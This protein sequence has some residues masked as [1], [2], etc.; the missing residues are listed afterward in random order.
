MAEVK[1]TTPNKKKQNPHEGHRKRVWQELARMGIDEDTH[2][3]KVLELVLFFTIPRKDTNVLA[4]NLLSYFNNSFVDVMEA[5]VEQLMEVPGISEYSAVHIKSILDVA[6]YYQNRKAKAEKPIFSRKSGSAYLVSM[7]TD[8]RVEKA[9]ML[10]LDNANRFLA[11]T[12]LSEGDELSVA[13]STRKII[14]KVT[15]IGATQVILAHN[16]PRGA[17]V[18]SKQDIQFT[19]KLAS[20]LSGIGVVF[21]DH[22]IVAEHDYVS[23]RD[24]SE[25]ALLFKI[26]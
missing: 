21:S 2:P 16:H 7:L 18:P 10:C 20:A 13:L 24:S 8:A 25:Y 17:A 19:S 6:R 9:Y 3:H 1:K 4:H 26:L 23:M 14:E 12:K 15:K 5:S 22:I 11:C